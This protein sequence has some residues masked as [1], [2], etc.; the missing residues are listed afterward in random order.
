MSYPN[1]PY[2]AFENTL[3]AIRQLQNMV[4]NAIENDEP[5]DFSSIQEKQAFEELQ[6]QMDALQELMEQYNEMSDYDEA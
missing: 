5:F 4:G 2:C 6:I 3:S 1:M